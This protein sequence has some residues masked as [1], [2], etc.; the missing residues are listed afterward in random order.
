M[1]YYKPKNSWRF[2]VFWMVGKRKQNVIVSYF[3]DDELSFKFWY[4][5]L[6]N[7]NVAKENNCYNFFFSEE[8]PNINAVD[9]IVLK[10]PSL[11]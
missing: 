6:F 8:I 5:T 9:R 11:Y 7:L 10:P 3:T 2:G 1:R 4:I